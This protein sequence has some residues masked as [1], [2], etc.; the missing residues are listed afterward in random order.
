MT[1]TEFVA[2]LLF[3]AAQ[4]LPNH[5]EKVHYEQLMAAE[6]TLFLL[7]Y[8]EANCSHHSSDPLHECE[9]VVPSWLN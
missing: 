1:L 2:G 8:P 3:E 6:D 4:K 7:H 5:N 9:G